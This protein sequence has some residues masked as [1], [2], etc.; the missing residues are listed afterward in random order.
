MANAPRRLVTTAILS[1][2]LT[3]GSAA[4]HEI[5]V[6]G[7]EF[8]FEPQRVEAEVGETV[9]I[10][11]KNEGRLSHNLTFEGL[12]AETE[13]IQAGNTTTVKVTPQ[14]PGTYRFICT[15][16]GHAEAGMEGRLVVNG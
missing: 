8:T 12:E 5:T 9:E 1:V 16:P 7:E 3:T 10:R 14:S 11:F 15:V 13:T 6:V 4:A 2:A